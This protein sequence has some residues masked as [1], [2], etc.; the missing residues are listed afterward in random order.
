MPNFKML[1]F[2]AA[3]VMV[4]AATAFADDPAMQQNGSSCPGGGPWCGTSQQA[5]DITGLT[6]LEYI[7]SSAVVAGTDWTGW[8]EGTV[9]GTEAELLHF[10][11]T[12]S[13][14]GAVFLYCGGNPANVCSA[15]DDVLPLYEN[16]NVTATF[17]MTNGNSFPQYSPGTTHPG[18]GTYGGG[19]AAYSVL[20]T[21]GIKGTAV[22]PEPSSVL[23]L[24]TMM[25][26][27]AAFARRKFSAGA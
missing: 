24:G 22:T 7:F 9:N 6:T 14:A 12:G 5:L 3:A 21:T 16:S 11:T 2:F 26:A 8:A 17:N 19:A 20:W 4:F 13:G 10:V 23:L 27:L 1:P 18:A 15:N 25:I